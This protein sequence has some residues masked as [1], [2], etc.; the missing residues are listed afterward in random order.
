LKKVRI[1]ELSKLACSGDS[2][3]EE[4]KTQLFDL[5]RE[6]KYR[7]FFLSYLNKYRSSGLFEI[8]KHCFGIIG[9][10]LNQI[11]DEV[12]LDKDFESARYCLILSQ[13]YHYNDDD[14]K[15]ISLQQK[16]E[17]HLLFK[18]LEFWESFIACKK[19]LIF[20]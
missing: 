6:K 8:S 19:K 20:S 1:T 9:D 11:L 14:G 3:T 12:I 4:H 15:K 2:Y 16:L 5:L 7:L 17:N 10:I 18:S 13:T